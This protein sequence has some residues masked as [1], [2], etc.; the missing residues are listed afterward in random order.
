[1]PPAGAARYHTVKK[2][3][4]LWTIAE[5]YYGKGKGPQW[6]VIKEANPGLNPKR[7]K[8]GDKILIPTLPEKTPRPETAAGNSAAAGRNGQ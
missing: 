4:S 1:M 5:Q 7:M 3:E 6:V 8:P 2:R